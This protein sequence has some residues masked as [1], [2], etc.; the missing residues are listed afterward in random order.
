MAAPGAGNGSTNNRNR[1]PREENYFPLPFISPT[2]Q[3]SNERNRQNF[4]KSMQEEENRKIEKFNE[5][6]EVVQNEILE[7]RT[8]K[9]V[10]YG[11]GTSYQSKNIFQILSSKLRNENENE[12]T[13]LFHIDNYF[14]V[15]PR[16][17][18]E[19]LKEI[20]D[21]KKLMG[22]KYIKKYPFEEIKSNIF[23]SRNL[24]ILF[25]P[26][27]IKSNYFIEYQDYDKRKF[28]KQKTIAELI[29][30][31][32]P[33]KN[34]LFYAMLNFVKNNHFNEFY[35]FNDAHSNYKDISLN[36]YWENMCELFHILDKANADKKYIISTFKNFKGKKEAFSLENF[37]EKKFIYDFNK[38]LL[39]ETDTKIATNIMN[40]LSNTLFI[41]DESALG[42]GAGPGPQPYTSSERN[43]SN[44]VR[45]ENIHYEENFSAGEGYTYGAVGGRRKRTTTRKQKKR[46]RKNRK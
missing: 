25:V 27:A 30:M 29:E 9:R 21:V 40:K 26:F 44:N 33:A 7:N 39:F 6:V 28:I 23:K 43:S 13:L 36:M 4:E 22:K 11:I 17:N 20:D 34:N 38:N 12:V 1:G 46:S 45:S 16:F 15:D 8:L 2:I 37:A 32:K 5:L 41:P 19:R 3:Y 31:C 14:K 35:I 18:D 42:A 24:F 10:I